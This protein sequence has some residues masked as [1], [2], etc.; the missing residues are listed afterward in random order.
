MFFTEV[1]YR[2]PH[3]KLEHLQNF[4]DIPVRQDSQIPAKLLDWHYLDA[5]SLQPL[6]LLATLTSLDLDMAYFR[7]GISSL[8]PSD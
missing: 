7:V 5:R 1:V 6:S 2:A 8:S 4:P 3:F